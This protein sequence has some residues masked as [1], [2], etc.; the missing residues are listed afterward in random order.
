MLGTGFGLKLCVFIN[1]GASW[2]TTIDEYM[3]EVEYQ[4]RFS[5]NAGKSSNI[6]K[7]SNF[8]IGL[9]ADCSQTLHFFIFYCINYF[10][11]S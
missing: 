8:L 6:I 9:T 11:D 7:L 2:L 5:T 3:S 10:L 4:L 1:G